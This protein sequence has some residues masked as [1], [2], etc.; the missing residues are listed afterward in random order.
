[1]K[2]INL[3]YIAVFVLM[4]AVV[5][6]NIDSLRNLLK[7]DD[8]NKMELYVEIS[9]A[10]KYVSLDSAYSYAR[11][12]IDNAKDNKDLFIAY[13]QMINVYFAKNQINK[14][15]DFLYRSLKI[16]KSID[17]KEDII[18]TYVRI[19]NMYDKLSK[20]DSSIFY[21][22]FALALVRNTI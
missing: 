12:A 16:A 19:G 9:E 22:N 3:I 18:N 5:Y 6:A 8:D 4:T 10:Y 11:K 20:Y 2:R 13:D 17:N 1:M 14:C 15:L 21:F 7:V